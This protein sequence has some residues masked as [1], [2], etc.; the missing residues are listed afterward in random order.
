MSRAE[1]FF[2]RALHV[3][4][5]DF[6]NTCRQQQS[7]LQSLQLHD[8]EN[9]VNTDVNSNDMGDGVSSTLMKTDSST[10]SHSS[11]N[12]MKKKQ[13][14]SVDDNAL[15]LN[16]ATTSALSTGN[17]QSVIS[18]YVTDVPTAKA[19]NDTS[20]AYQ[21]QMQQYQSLPRSLT[22]HHTSPSSPHHHSNNNNE[23][24]FT[25]IIIILPKSVFACKCNFF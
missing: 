11:G 16:T 8:N 17:K 3:C 14:Y 13:F 18:A 7:A 6:I 12:G 24:N 2:L 4:M 25:I 1:A 5:P 20:L 19:D 23:G 15:Q 22:Q 9:T 21:A 10:G